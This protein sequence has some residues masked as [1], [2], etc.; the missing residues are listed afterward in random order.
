MRQH[1]HGG[2]SP[3]AS[4]ETSRS[5]RARASCTA[6]RANPRTIRH[7]G[8]RGSPN[9][10]KPASFTM[11][12][13]ATNAPLPRVFCL[14]PPRGEVQVRQTRN[15]CFALCGRGFV[16]PSLIDTNSRSPL[17]RHGTTVVLQLLRRATIPNGRI[18]LGLKQV[19]T[20]LSVREGC[21]YH[22]EAVSCPIASP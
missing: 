8:P 5:R 2:A 15:L 17:S 11:S 10:R 12:S 19:E 6:T 22:R 9:W 18:R 21:A 14:S 1:D 7:S 13:S 16:G 4:C 3:A 20:W